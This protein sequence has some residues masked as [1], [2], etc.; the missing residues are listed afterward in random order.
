MYLVGVGALV[1]L[2]SMEK[3]ALSL[4][5]SLAVILVFLLTAYGYLKRERKVNRLDLL[6]VLTVGLYIPENEQDEMKRGKAAYHALLG[7]V[8]LHISAFY[9]LWLYYSS[10]LQDFITNFAT[11]FMI[12]SGSVGVGVFTQSL[13]RS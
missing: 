9:A 1:L 13:K 5:N 11:L 4:V 10:N 12:V 8:T 7:M 6:A 3:I 2:A